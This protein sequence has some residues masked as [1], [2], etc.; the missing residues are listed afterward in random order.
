MLVDDTGVSAH[1]VSA[2][3]SCCRSLLFEVTAGTLVARIAA[4]QQLVVMRRRPGG[5]S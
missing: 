5:T 2:I 1:V 4:G 3:R